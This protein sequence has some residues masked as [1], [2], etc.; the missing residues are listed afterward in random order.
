MPRQSTR[1]EPSAEADHHAIIKSKV[2]YVVGDKMD[3]T[4]VV[5]VDTLTPHPLYK[6]RVRRSR[7]FLAHDETNEAQVGDY[8]RI[9]EGRPRSKRK[10]WQLAA[11]L[12]P[13]AGRIQAEQVAADLKAEEA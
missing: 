10:S 9:A 11:V 3:K 12:R 2:G 13:S 8:V 6:K 4:I 7:K 5:R 1:T